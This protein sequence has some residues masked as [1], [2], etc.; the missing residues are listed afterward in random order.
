MASFLGLRPGTAHFVG[1]YRIRG[2]RDLDLNGF[3]AIPENQSLRDFGYEGFTVQDVAKAGS[4]R[5]FSFQPLVRDQYDD[6]SISDGTLERPGLKRLLADIEDG[7][8][9]VVVVYKIDRLS[10]LLMDF[11]KL[12]EVFD[13]NGVT[14]VSVT[15]S[16]NTTTSMGRLTDTR[17]MTIEV[18]TSE[19]G[20]DFASF[21]LSRNE[22]QSALASMAHQFHL[23]TLAS[24]GP[25]LAVLTIDQMKVHV[26]K[27]EG[28]GIW[29]VLKVPFSA[30][31]ECF[32]DFPRDDR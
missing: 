11:S 8:V 20:P 4:V 25:Q 19:G 24:A 30:L 17:R 14:F 15:Q 23:W 31:K 3:W 12:V 16:F 28:A 29:E 9:D 27:D 6:G 32:W 18:K 5:Q 1:L 26:P 13:R 2:S 10:R 22:W 7:L 21:H